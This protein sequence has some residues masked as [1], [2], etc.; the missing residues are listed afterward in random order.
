MMVIAN[1]GMT[2]APYIIQSVDGIT[3]KQDRTFSINAPH[4]GFDLIQEG[5]GKVVRD[6]SGTGYSAF[7]DSPGSARNYING[8]TGTAERGS[9]KEKNDS[10]FVGYVRPKHLDPSSND[11]SKH[12]LV[13]VCLLADTGTGGV[14]AGDTVERVMRRLS[15]Y[16]NWEE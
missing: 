16:Y 1:R 2:M 7:V 8:K 11:P 5:M 12:T 14:H 9:M 6:R 13:F 3:L 15:R 10:W 4:W